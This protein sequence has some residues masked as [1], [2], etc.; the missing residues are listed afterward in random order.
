MSQ[1]I[2][3][4]HSS[5]YASE[6][7]SVGSGSAQ[8]SA[9]TFPNQQYG[10]VR[11]ATTG[12]IHIRFDTDPTATLQDLLLTSGESELFRLR[13]GDKVAFIKEGSA[14]SINITTL[15]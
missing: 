15:E 1:A 11:I 5:N 2:I 13:S 10:L 12:D 8:S 7:H 14:C 4:T 6:S 3:Q 9:F